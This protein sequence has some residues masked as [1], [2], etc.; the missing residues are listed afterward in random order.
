MSHRHFDGFALFSAQFIRANLIGFGQFT[1]RKSIEELSQFG[2]IDIEPFRAWLACDSVFY[3][4]GVEVVV[5]KAIARSITEN[6]VVFQYQLPSNIGRLRLLINALFDRLPF[7]IADFNPSVVI[8]NARGL[9]GIDHRDD[10]LK[11]L[12]LNCHYTI[13][14]TCVSMNSISLSARPYF[15]YNWRSISAID[16][17]QSMSDCDVKS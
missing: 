16:C 14:F 7:G 1:T 5:G 10:S 8:Q 3:E 2:R 6:G 11:A 13:S 9:I 17:D 4:I 15:S 12:N